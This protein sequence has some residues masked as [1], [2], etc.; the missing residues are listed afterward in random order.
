MATRRKPPSTSALKHLNQ[1][2]EEDERER[3]HELLLLL[4]EAAR[5]WA[6]VEAGRLM[7][8]AELRANYL[9]RR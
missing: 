2:E 3:E 4:E 8:P 5:G 7:T 9:C 6:D 1:I